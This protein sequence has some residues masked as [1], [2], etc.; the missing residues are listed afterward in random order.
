M[1]ESHHHVDKEVVRRDFIRSLFTGGFLLWF[2]AFLY[3]VFRYLK[4]REEEDTTNAVQSVVAAKIS[5]IKTVH[6]KL[7]K[8]GTKPAW[9]YENEKKD[10]VAVIATC[11]HLGCTV[12]FYPEKNQFICGCH[13]G[14][15]DA[16]G[17]NIAGPPPRPLTPLKVLFDGDNIIASKA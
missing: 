9:V 10:I 6:A 4:P 13:G 15:Y 11:S 17:K 16:T 1:S 12:T 8:F 3:P 2:G 7:F 5:E 14:T